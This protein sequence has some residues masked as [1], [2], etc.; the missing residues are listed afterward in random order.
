MGG[1]GDPDDWEDPNIVPVTPAENYE[2]HRLQAL[3]WPNEPGVIKERILSMARGTLK[4]PE[5]FE[6]YVTAIYDRCHIYST[7]V[8][9]FKHI[10][11][12]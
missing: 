5:E 11:L 7:Y 2:A 8:K 12:Y 6:K 4:T 1:A 10:R 9:D 3:A